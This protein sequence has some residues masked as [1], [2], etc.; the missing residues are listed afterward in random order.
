MEIQGEVLDQAISLA[1]N[2]LKAEAGD[3][4]QRGLVEDFLGRVRDL[5]PAEA[6]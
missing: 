3:A 6:R 2:R 1:T 4:E 5:D